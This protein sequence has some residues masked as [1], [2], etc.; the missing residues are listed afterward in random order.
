MLF[1]PRVSSGFETDFVGENEAVYMVFEHLFTTVFAIEM[2]CKL[3]VERWEYFRQGWNMMDFVL[4]WMSIVDVWI[5]VGMSG[6][7]L[8]EHFRPPHKMI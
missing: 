6:A 7:P 2:V 4:V 8:R 5:F 1:F 3:Q